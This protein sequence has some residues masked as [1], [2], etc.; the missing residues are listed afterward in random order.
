[1]EVDAT[2]MAVLRRLPLDVSSWSLFVDCKACARDD[3]GGRGGG[4]KRT[5]DKNHLCGPNQSNDVT[6]DGA[7]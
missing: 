3:F 1:M 7:Q 6:Y 5:I 4:A 2:E